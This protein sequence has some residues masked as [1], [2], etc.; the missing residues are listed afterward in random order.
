MVDVFIIGAMRTPLGKYG[1]SLSPY[2]AIELGTV[3]IKAAVQNAGILPSQV[4]EVVMGNVI[5][6]GL[7]QDP[8]RQA[9]IAA[10]IPVEVSGSTVNMVCASGMLAIAN[11]FYQIKAGQRDVMVVGGMESMSNAPFILDSSFRR[12]NKGLSASRPVMDAMIK[13]GLWDFKY[14]KHMGA[15][16]DEWGKDHGITREMADEYA[17]E[18]FKRASDATKN[19]YFKKEIA[20]IKGFDLDE[21]IRETNKEM[22]AG[23]KPAFTP[24]GILTAGNSSQITDGAAALVLAN[25]DFIN[26]NSLEKRAK[27]IGFDT[28]S[29]DP[30]DFPFSP[31]PSVKNLLK[32]IGM[33]IGDFDLVEHNEAFSVASIAV[34]DGLGIDWKKFN[35]RGGAIA[36]GHPLGASGARI[37]VTLLRELEDLRLGRGIATICH[38]GGGAYSMAIEAI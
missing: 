7:G 17:L 35:I 31:V 33:K 22:L 2:S 11:A 13:D 30:Y 24:D 36:L 26:Q 6:A 5:E 38:G 27:I 15:I 37:V 12:E 14:N 28:T 16:S 9:A 18:S 20:P 8:A 25:E 19:G 23:L 3:A 29:M 10:G 1:K 34:R 4:Q 32:R 21:G